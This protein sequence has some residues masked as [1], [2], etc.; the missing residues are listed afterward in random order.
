MGFLRKIWGFISAYKGAAPVVEHRYIMASQRIIGLLILL[1]A[2]LSLCTYIFFGDAVSLP[3]LAGF[4]LY[5][6]GLFLLFKLD[7][8]RFGRLLL[9]ISVPLFA[10]LMSVIIKRND[11]VIQEFTYYETRVIILA[12]GILPL[13]LF[14]FREAKW[15]IGAMLTNFILLI[16]YDPVHN[17]LGVGYYQTGHDDQTYYYMNVIFTIGSWVLMASILFLDRLNFQYEKKNESLLQETQQQNNALALKNQELKNLYQEIELRNEEIIISS[18]HLK[19]ANTLIE[20]QNEA[21]NSRNEELGS[22]VEKTSED[23]VQANARLRTRNEELEHFSYALSHHLRAPVASLLGLA[24][25]YE[26]ADEAMKGEIIKRIRS[27]A[28]NMDET[29]HGLSGLLGHSRTL[30]NENIET[31]ALKEE[32]Q[33]VR[34]LLNKHL[35]RLEGEFLNDIPEELTL[36]LPQGFLHAI[37]YN[38]VQNSLKYYNPEK[39]PRIELYTQNGHEDRLSLVIADNGLGIDLD[40]YRDQLFQM[41]RRFHSHTKGNG[42]GLYLVKKLMDEIGGEVEV[43]SKPLAGTRFTL[44]F[45]A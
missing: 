18:E 21:L 13:L 38:L 36:T 37:L 8:H 41:S 26:G 1:T 39:P 28:E 43:S 33:K 30:Y 34:L 7:F 10:L 6:L 23:L 14:S 16:A 29:I 5:L 3:Y 4:S 24:Q 35:H 27:S 11:V 12:T 42:L 2:L 22:M 19:E 45:P 15:M 9:S 31:V 20:E 44:H 25:L 40:Q 32:A 17:F